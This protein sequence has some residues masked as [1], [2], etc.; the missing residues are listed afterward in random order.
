MTNYEKA[1]TLLDTGKANKHRTYKDTGILTILCKD[2]P[3]GKELCA[4][5][6]PDKEYLDIVGSANSILYYGNISD[7][8]TEITST[9]TSRKAL[10]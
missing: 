2:V 7:D 6:Y 9:R 8:L 10:I 4:Y 3:N 5:A 1:V